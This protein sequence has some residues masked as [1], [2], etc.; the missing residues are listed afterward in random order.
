M[1]YVATFIKFILRGTF[2]SSFPGMRRFWL[3]CHLVADVATFTKIHSVARSALI[4]SL[5]YKVLVFSVTSWP[6]LFVATLIRIHF[7]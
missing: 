7:A 2:C 5:D 1:L 4:F 6:M 3:F